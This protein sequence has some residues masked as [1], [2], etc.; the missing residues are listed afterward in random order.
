MKKKKN[1]KVVAFPNLEERLLK[2][3]MEQL[4]NKN[5]SRALEYFQQLQEHNFYQEAEVGI[6]LCLLELGMLNDAKEKCKEL[7][8]KGIGDYFEVLH[9]YTT[10][11]MQL[12]EYSE[13]V[14]TLETVL[15]EHPPPKEYAESIYHLLQLGRKLNKTEFNND[16][17]MVDV[18]HVDDELGLLKLDSIAEQITLVQKLQTANLRPYL[19]EIEQFLGDNSSH[20]FVQALLLQL[21]KEQ[22]VDMMITVRKFGEAV[23][24]N[25]VN[26]PYANEQGFESDVHTAL[27]AQLGQ[28]N[29]VLFELVVELWQ[30]TVLMRYPLSFVPHN[31][32]VWAAALYKLGYEMQG[33]SLSIE[34]LNEHYVVGET[35]LNEALSILLEV[36]R[37]E[38]NH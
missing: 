13:I 3:G 1:S 20:P 9:I 5:Y 37:I 8:N 18:D 19:N 29:P 34:E 7:L 23:I 27:E 25:P 11:L 38:L 14:V 33:I 12:K 30:R 35:D 15:Q 26:I 24:V 2:L 10:I 6:V 4:D 31:A 17:Q 32:Q 22:E 16:T 28:N 36:E 21:L